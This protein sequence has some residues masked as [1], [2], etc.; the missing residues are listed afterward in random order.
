MIEKIKEFKEWLIARG[1]NPATAE[2]YTAD[3]RMAYAGA[4][5]PY[6]RL[7]DHKLAPKTV[8]RTMAALRAWCRF[9]KDG[10]LLEK[11]KDI[12]LPP[13]E[14]KI[15][16]VPLSKEEWSELVEEIEEANY[17]SPG[18][19][20][21]LGIMAIRGLRVGDVL[22]MTREE[23]ERGMATG[24]LA[25]EA[26]RG[27]RIE[28][29]VKPIAD[30]LSLLLKQD[31]WYKVRDLVSMR[32]TKSELVK[33]NSATQQL[34]RALKAV[35]EKIGIPG[36]D[37]YPHRLRRTVATHF[38]EAA[39]GNIEKLRAFMSWSNIVTAAGYADYHRRDELEAI[40]DTM[41]KKK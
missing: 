9:N 8:R 5:P 21:A 14:R 31:E 39:G 27:K 1:R 4:N 10:E 41:R 7:L 12:Q 11:L 19:R 34:S 30:Y 22:R 32:S 18:E 33:Q 36:R 6:G 23:V 37:I 29:S 16:K 2:G 24:I 25:Y 26:K 40:A 17:L 3:I 38:L 35:G 13:A 28:I 15:A 20:A